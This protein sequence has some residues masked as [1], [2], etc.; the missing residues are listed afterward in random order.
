MHSSCSVHKCTS[1]STN[2]RVFEQ[3]EKEE[4]REKWIKFLVSSG[5]DVHKNVVYR[6]CERHFY[7]TDFKFNKATEKSLHPGAVPSI[8]IIRPRVI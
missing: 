6:V 3:P 8:S 4:I 1:L 5:K 7:P 2:V